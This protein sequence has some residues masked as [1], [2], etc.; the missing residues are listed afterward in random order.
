MA[1]HMSA[2]PAK[3]CR[4]APGALGSHDFS[5][6]RFASR[7]T[8]LGA[9]HGAVARLP[10]LD[11]DAALGPHGGGLRGTAQTSVPC[12]DVGCDKHA[13]QVCA[14]SCDREHVAD[15]RGVRVL[16]IKTGAHQVP[17]EF[18]RGPASHHRRRR[19]DP[20]PC[21]RWSR[22]HGCNARGSGD[23]GR[24]SCERSADISQ[25][26]L[27]CFLAAWLVRSRRLS[28]AKLPSSRMPV[29]FQDFCDSASCAGLFA[30]SPPV[31]RLCC[32]GRVAA[33]SFHG[34]ASSA[35]TDCMKRRW[36]SG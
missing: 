10:G 32:A 15:H 14:R 36:S 19:H 35:V 20:T 25:S 18:E 24:R 2:K 30:C 34:S 26:G 17:P 8:S 11:A 16:M 4:V 5:D 9:L 33:C 1:G 29:R 21:E 3:R 27:H 6:A 22:Q 7:S 28:W 13:R 23:V 31:F 12:S